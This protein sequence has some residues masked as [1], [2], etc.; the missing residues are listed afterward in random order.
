MYVPDTD[1]RRVQAYTP[2]GDPLGEMGAAGSPPIEVVPKQVAVTRSGQ[3]SLYVMGADA[4]VRM[5]LESVAPPPQS[6]SDPDVVSLIV[7]A[8]LVAMMALAIWSR[9]MRRGAAPLRLAT[10][11]R[12]VRLEPV[13]GAQRQ[14]EQTHADE[15]LLIADQAKGEHSPPA[16]RTIP[17]ATL[18]PSIT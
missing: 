17:K 18:K 12:P 8:M 5:D 1:H 4:V 9:R 3:L 6:G 10:S 7:I 2:Q 11:G 14:H 16:S 15:H 13:N